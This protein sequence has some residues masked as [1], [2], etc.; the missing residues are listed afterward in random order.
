[1]ALWYQN[2]ITVS[3]WYYGIKM[4]LW[5]QNGNTISKW[6]YGIKMAIRY[7]NGNMHIFKYQINPLC[8]EGIP[9]CYFNISDK[10]QTILDFCPFSF[11]PLSFPVAINPS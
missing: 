1:M 11:H 5:Y 3:K 9:H 4:V 10:Y 8:Y 2:G 7:Q 6:H